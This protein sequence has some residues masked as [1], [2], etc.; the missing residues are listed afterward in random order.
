MKRFAKILLAGVF[1]AAF[2]FFGM[3]GKKV[4]AFSGGPEPSL[5]GA[6]GEGTCTGCHAG[7]PS[8]G[9]L[10][11][12]GLPANYMADQEYTLT[13]TIAQ[14]GRPRFGFQTT[15]I[16]SAGRQAG[17]LIVSDAARTQS[18]NGSV[19]GNQRTYIEHNLAGTNPS[20]QGQNIWTFRWRA[21]AASTGRVTFYVAGNAANGDFLNTGDSIY[22]TN[23]SSEPGAQPTPTPTPSPTPRAFAS[24]SA[25]SFKPEGALSPDSIAA[26]FSQEI[27]APN[28]L[29]VASSVPLPETLVD[30]I[31]RVTDSAGTARNAGLFF[32]SPGQINYVI[33]VGTSAGT[34]TISVLRSGQVVAQGT[35]QISAL[36]PGI[37]TA[38]Q[39]TGLAAAQIFR[40]PAG[41][42]EGRFE[43]VAQFNS[44]TGQFEP[45]PIDLGPEGDQLALIIYG[46]GFRNNTGPG[47]VTA[48]IGGVTSQVLYASVAPGFVGLDQA[49]LTLPRTLAGRGPV[50]VVFT[51]DG[52]PANTVTVV[53]R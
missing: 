8:G 15:V 3:S 5:T 21:P 38:N 16:D 24:V 6:P 26:G 25:A 4:T 29:A 11:I 50:D 35:T 17:T 44:Q 13:V 31:V 43:P 20:S 7:G 48:T 18:V 39:T 28:V 30:V 45:V 46:T 32:V 2:V 14:Q 10:Q 34:A 40:V 23:A 36:T 9:T 47:G 52:Q 53:F 51:V 19:Q 33:P 49:N 42:S 12:T 1:A 37:F 41:Q 22:T 27:V